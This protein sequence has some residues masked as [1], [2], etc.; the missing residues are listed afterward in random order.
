MFANGFTNAFTLHHVVRL[1]IVLHRPATQPQQSC[2]HVPSKDEISCTLLASA[3]ELPPRAVEGKLVESCEK[4]PKQGEGS[5]SLIAD[6][7][8]RS[9]MGKL[10]NFG[11]E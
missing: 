11:E 10:P 5:S 1:R 3:E 6:D 8:P 2:T 9:P 4:K 7:Q